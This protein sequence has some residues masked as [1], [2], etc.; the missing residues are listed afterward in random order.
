MEREPT[1]VHLWFSLSYAAYLCVN[2][3]LLQSMPL[4]WQYREMPVALVV[5]ADLE[6]LPHSRACGWRNHPHG[7]DCHPNCPTC[8]G[9]APLVVPNEHSEEP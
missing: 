5:E 4:D 7:S 3:S 6:R 2:R 8:H 9:H 1:D